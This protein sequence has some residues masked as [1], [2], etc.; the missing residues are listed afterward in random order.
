MIAR[1]FAKHIV[2]LYHALSSLIALQSLL[3]GKPLA[4]F[5]LLKDKLK[6]IIPAKQQEFKKLKQQLGNEEALHVADDQILEG[7]KG[8]S[9]LFW[10]CSAI[11]PEKVIILLKS[12]K[13]L[14]LIIVGCYI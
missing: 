10:E 13:Q 2:T 4:R 1:A 7:L 6:E 8:V 9:G 5:S 12:P 11:D 3:Q 14:C